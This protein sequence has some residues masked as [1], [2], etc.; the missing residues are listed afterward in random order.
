[1][2]VRLRR[3]T[4]HPG[5]DWVRGWSP[6]GR[7]STVIFASSRATPTM[8]YKQL[9]TVGLDGAFPE[10]LPMPMA[11]RGVYS[12]DGRQ[13]AYTRMA[14]PFWTWKRYRG[15]QTLPIWIFDLETYDHI[16]IPHVNASDT[17]PC[18]IGDCVYFLSDR[19]HTMNLFVYNTNPR[20][21]SN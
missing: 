17:F 13:M 7:V 21:W 9:F 18:W 19:N 3:L 1:M 5:G 20:P 12:P 10:P 14:E 4:Y 2:A 6:D 11:E 8:R 15:G 16:E